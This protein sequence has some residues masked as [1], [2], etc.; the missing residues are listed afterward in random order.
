MWPQ[1][2]FRPA[3]EGRSGAAPYRGKNSEKWGLVR[4]LVSR[5]AGP[6]ADEGHPSDNRV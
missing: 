1:M 3:R 2:H 5:F 6:G 4:S